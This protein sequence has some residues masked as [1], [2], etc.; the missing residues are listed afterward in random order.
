MNG[1]RFNLNG[2]ILLVNP[3]NILIS[4]E[5]GLTDL[6]FKL[7]SVKFLEGVLKFNEVKIIENV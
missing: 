5:K 3:K 4:L 6:L 2:G 7:A 1:K